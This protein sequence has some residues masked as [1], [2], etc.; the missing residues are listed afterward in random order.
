MEPS[1]VEEFDIVA[2]ASAAADNEVAAQEPTVVDVAAAL[3]V[4]QQKDP[5]ASAAD[6][7][8]E[9]GRRKDWRLPF[10][11]PGQQLVV[12]PTAT[13]RLGLLQLIAVVAVL[14]AAAE[15]A[16]AA[17][18]MAA[19][20]LVAAFAASAAAEGDEIQIQPS[21]TSDPQTEAKPLMPLAADILEARHI[22]AVAVEYQPLFEA[23]PSFLREWRRW[24]RSRSRRMDLMGGRM[25]PW[26]IVMRLEVFARAMV[27]TVG[28]LLK[29]SRLY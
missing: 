2:K 28:M 1:W 25:M 11:Q 20:E 12:E 17:V 4:V 27:I 8:V 19:A 24:N 21:A 23:K 9:E 15:L 14:A 29:R 16:L 26:S 18:E 6:F 22:A 7:A 5:F 13:W 10:A 3:A